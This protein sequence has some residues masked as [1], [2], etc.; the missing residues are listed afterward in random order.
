MYICIYVY[1]Y[2]CIYV[3][4]YICIHV[5]MYTCIFVYLYICIHV[6]MSKCIYVDSLLVALI[7]TVQFFRARFF[8]RGWIVLVL[9]R[10]GPPIGGILERFQ[11]ILDLPKAP[12]SSE[13]P[14]KLFFE[15]LRRLSKAFEGLGMRKLVFLEYFGEVLGSHFGTKIQPEC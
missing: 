4:M 15:G 1:M 8:R 5:Y 11:V 2:I 7:L 6:Y 3:C 14:Q 13:F 9:G 12:E 10:F